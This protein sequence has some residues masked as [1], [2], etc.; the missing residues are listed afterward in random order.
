MPSRA[1]VAKDQWP[2]RRAAN[3]A[4]R[5]VLKYFFDLFFRD[6]VFCTVLDIAIGIVVEVSYDRAEGHFD[7]SENSWHY[8]T[9]LRHLRRARVSPPRRRHGP[10][11]RIL[12]LPRFPSLQARLYEG[13]E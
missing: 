12:R 9:T 4:V 7:V 3:V 5:G 10:C 8:N 1:G 6:V 2:A 11:S 13:T